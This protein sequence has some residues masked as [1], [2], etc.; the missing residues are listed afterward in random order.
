MGSS[1]NDLATRLQILK[2]RVE[3]EAALARQRLDYIVNQ[4]QNVPRELQA[5]ESEMLALQDTI[6]S[7]TCEILKIGSEEFETLGYRLFFSATHKDLKNLYD[8]GE[9]WELMAGHLTK[10]LELLDFLKARLEKD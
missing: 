7:T 10:T 1:S 2:F 6:R 9:Y 5:S 4:G 3:K 8:S